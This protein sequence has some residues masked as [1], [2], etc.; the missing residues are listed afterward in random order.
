MP[1]CLFHSNALL[2]LILPP[3]LSLSSPPVFP[4]PTLSSS[5]DHSLAICSGHSLLSS[6]PLFPFF[7]CPLPPPLPFSLTPLFLSSSSSLFSECLEPEASVTVFMGIDFNDSTQAANFQLCTKEDHFSVSIQPAIGELLLPITMT[8]LD[9][10]KEKGKLLGMN[11]S[12]ATITMAAE[13]MTS[14]PISR[15][16]ATVA[17]L[18][19]VPS[20]QGNVHRGMPRERCV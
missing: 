6:S 8:E 9:F 14:Q 1:V 18:G 19:V 20:S 10:R 11:E 15:P 4:L 12:S 2:S 5:F 7:F 16:V 3:P 17:N 13:N